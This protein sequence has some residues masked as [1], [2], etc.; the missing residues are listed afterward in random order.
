MK[1][2]SLHSYKSIMIQRGRCKQFSFGFSLLELVIVVIIISI[3]LTIAIS[4]LIS[5]QTDAERVVMESTIGAMRSALGIKV[6]ESIVRQNIG[7]LPGYASSNPVALL[8]EVPDNYLGEFESEDPRAKEK[9]W[10]FETD[11]RAIVYVVDNASYFSGGMENPPRARFQIRLVY[12]DRNNN[13]TYDSGIDSIEGLRLA[14]ME[15]YK[16]TK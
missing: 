16:W 14:V 3:L 6:A 15:P 11:S 2:G 8:A 1:N 7:A 5:L 10:H 12:T 4:R 9:G 13:G